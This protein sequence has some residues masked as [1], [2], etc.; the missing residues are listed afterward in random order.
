MT[1]FVSAGRLPEL[2][3]VDDW[4]FLVIC[5]EI[6]CG[7][8]PANWFHRVGIGIRRPTCSRK[9]TLRG[10]F[11]ASGRNCIGQSSRDVILRSPVGRLAVT[12][13]GSGEV[14]GQRRRRVRARRD[15]RRLALVSDRSMANSSRVVS[16]SFAESADSAWT[17]TRRVSSSSAVASED[18]SAEVAAMS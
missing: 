17:V 3:V 8:V 4:H 1:I 10:A 2:L 11:A 15:S 13:G 18:S 9:G 6:A 12:E 7:P 14:L 16:S 5:D